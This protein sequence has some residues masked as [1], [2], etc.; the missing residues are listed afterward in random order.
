MAT[1]GPITLDNLIALNDEIAALAR[2]GV[3]LDRGL[4]AIGRDMPG[5]LGRTAQALGR[6]LEAGEDLSVAINQSGDAFPPIY[7]AVV[8]AGLKSGRLSVALEGISRTARR[9]SDTRRTMIVSLIYPILVLVI[10]MVVFR[11]T[12]T[13]TVPLVE[14]TFADIGV[15]LPRWY[16]VLSAIA[17]WLLQALPWIQVGGVVLGAVYIYRISRASVLDTNPARGGT[18]VGQILQAGRLAT[19]SETLALLLEQSLPLADALELACQSSGDRGLRLAGERLGQSIQRGEPIRQLPAGFPPLLGWM[20]IGGGQSGQLVAA[21]R[22]M[23]ENYRR[24]AA[25]LGAW[26]TIYFPLVLSAGVCGLVV[27]TY[28]VLAMMPFYF[29]MIQMSLPG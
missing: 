3:P 27:A 22:R 28:V 11:M 17:R 25:R 23:A 15:V 5:R 12:M 20:L 26:L 6:R 2:A 21:L 8:L 29:L 13:T 4:L 19:F 16:A 14:A 24:R 10:A 18:T 1:S 9:V 7:R